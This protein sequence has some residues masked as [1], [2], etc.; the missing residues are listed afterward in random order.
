MVR[1]KAN[2]ARLRLSGY[3]SA[4]LRLQSWAGVARGWTL[5]QEEISCETETALYNVNARILSTQHV[6]TLA[7]DS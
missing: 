3:S 1:L 7:W 4:R 5:G 6:L 2:P